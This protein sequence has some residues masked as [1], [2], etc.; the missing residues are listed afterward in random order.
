YVT[1]QPGDLIFTG[2]PGKTSA[3]KPGDVC[4]VELEG[5]GVLRNPVVLGK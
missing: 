2:T 1:L 3:I 5:V 4:E